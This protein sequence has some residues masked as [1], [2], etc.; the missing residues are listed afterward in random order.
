MHTD[1]V[2]TK[3]VIVLCVKFESILHLLCQTRIH[4]HDPIDAAILLFWMSTDQCSSICK[5]LILKSQ[6]LSYVMATVKMCLFLFVGLKANFNHLFI[7]HTDK[8]FYAYLL[9]LCFQHEIGHPFT[10]LKRH[11]SLWPI[12]SDF[13]WW[14]EYEFYFSVFQEQSSHYPNACMN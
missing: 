2:H 12:F 9:Y 5:P 7:M 10:N 6:T 4:H 13:L 14:C 1:S 8:L 11:L 3:H